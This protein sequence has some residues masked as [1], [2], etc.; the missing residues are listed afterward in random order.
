M[1]IAS[2]RYNKNLLMRLLSFEGLRVTSKYFCIILAN[3]IIVNIIIF[4][5]VCL[6][7]K[8]K[9]PI[10]VHIMGSIVNLCRRLSSSFATVLMVEKR[11][12]T[13]TDH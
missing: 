11:V 7:I 12:M 2:V 4:K 9:E 13:A 8:I 3:D 5:M 1:P 6:Y 10:Y